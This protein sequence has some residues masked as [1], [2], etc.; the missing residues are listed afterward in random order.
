MQTYE[1]NFPK[2]M[3]RKVF[4]QF[5][6]IHAIFVARDLRMRGCLHPSATTEKS[7]FNALSSLHAQSRK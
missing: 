6:F 7:L 5:L 1:K 3:F 4:K 2:R